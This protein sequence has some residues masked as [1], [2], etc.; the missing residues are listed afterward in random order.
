[1][2]AED[3]R[4]EELLAGCATLREMVAL[5]GVTKRSDRRPTRD[6]SLLFVPLR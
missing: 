4:D 5:E 6:W 3:V 2:V 1:M